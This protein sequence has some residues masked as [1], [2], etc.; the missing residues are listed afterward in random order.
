MKDYHK[1]I[2]KASSMKELLKQVTLLIIASAILAGV[3]VGL[4]IMLMA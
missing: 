4:C 1:S 2:E 3:T